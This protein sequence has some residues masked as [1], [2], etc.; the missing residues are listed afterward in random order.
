MSDD[1]VSR[2]VAAL[3]VRIRELEAQLIRMSVVVRAEGGTD[4]CTKCSTEGCTDCRTGQCTTCT[5]DEF[6]RV[7]LP[8]ELER[9]S[10]SE[11]VRRLQQAGRPS[12]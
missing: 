6:Q 9:L 4:N 2:D 12:K 8:G 10:G 5:G 3:A 11:L 7:L 1:L